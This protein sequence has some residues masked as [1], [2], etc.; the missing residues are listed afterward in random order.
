MISGAGRRR[1]RATRRKRLRQE[2]FAAAVE[3][4]AA[5]LAPRRRCFGRHAVSH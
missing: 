2:R 5:G 3:R 1:G 4:F